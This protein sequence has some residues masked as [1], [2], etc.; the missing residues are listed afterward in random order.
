VGT[1]EEHHFLEG[2]EINEAQKKIHD[3]LIDLVLSLLD[4]LEEPLHIETLNLL[5]QFLLIF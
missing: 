2:L 1:A 5:S 3:L 4:H